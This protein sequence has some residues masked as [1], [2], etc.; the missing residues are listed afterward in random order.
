VDICNG[1]RE[2]YFHYVTNPEKGEYSIYL[3]KIEYR[4]GQYKYQTIPNIH[5]VGNYHDSPLDKTHP[6]YLGE[7]DK[8]S[9]YKNLTQYGNLIL[10]SEGE[11]DP[12]VVKEALIAGLG[13]VVSECS[14]ANLDLE[15]EFITV[16]PNDKLLD[17]EYVGAKIAENRTYSLSHRE[18]IRE[19]A[20]AHFAWATI[21]DTYL[22]AIDP[23]P[24][25]NKNLVMKIALVGPGIMPIPPPGWGAVEILIW[26]YYQELTRMGHIVN[27]INDIRTGHRDQSAPNTPYCQ[28]LIRKINSGDYDFVHIHYDCFYHIMPYLTCKRIGITSHYP[29]IDQ[30]E[31]HARDGY[32]STFR[33]IC[34]NTRHVIFALSQKDYDTF[35]S[36]AT[37]KDR[38]YMTLNGANSSEIVAIDPVN[39]SHIDKSIYLGKV[40]ERKQQYRYCGIPGIDFYGKCETADFVGKECYKGE[41]GRTE[42]MAK[43]PQY[44]NMVL[45]STGENGTPLVIKEA[46]MA[47]LP[48]VTN[49]YS[50]NDLAV[51]LPFIDIIPDD[52]WG[53]IPYIESVIIENRKKSG[54]WK[55]IREYA[56]AHF[57]WETLVKNYG[58]LLQNT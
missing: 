6:Y 19:Y 27:I 36:N 50:A 41:P 21:V 34:A 37:N 18:S 3:A 7:W 46:L 2:D 11:A 56:M 44:G 29:Y 35:Y 31:K 54:M 8:P 26:D 58:V 47:G 30:P 25:S 33:G 9:L 51:D 49:K 1:A 13:V 45:L 39:R 40:E 14:S 17:L 42:L 4:K 12:L 57:S 10:L 23:P 48:V 55:E 24:T 15:R 5:F 43:L 22:T 53:D 20:L 52:K 16:I 28:E 32:D 38:I